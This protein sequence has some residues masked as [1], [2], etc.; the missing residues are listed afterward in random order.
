MIGRTSSGSFKGTYGF[1]SRLRNNDMFSDLD[2]AAR[3]G[4]EALSAAT[5]KDTGMT[6]NSWGYTITRSGRQVTIS[7]HNTNVNGTANIAIL[8]QY[9][10]GTGT[11]GYVAGQDYINPTMKPVFDK[12][13]ET[14][15][16][17]VN[18]G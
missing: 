6:A 14:V 12:I 4:V 8:L 9:G 7:W 2:S 11:G 10:H 3:A 5:P 13:A 18:S 15:W 1:L 17:K 16:K